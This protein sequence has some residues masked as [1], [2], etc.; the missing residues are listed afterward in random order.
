MRTKPKIINPWKVLL[1][2]SRGSISTI[3][4]LLIVIIVTVY[5]ITEENNAS[6]VKQ[7]AFSTLC[8]SERILY[9]ALQQLTSHLDLLRSLILKSKSLNFF[10]L[11]T[12]PIFT[13]SGIKLSLFLSVRYLKCCHI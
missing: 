3:Y 7:E 5:N 12:L 1:T 2:G 13:Y 8:N 9:F 6:N 4:P 10:L 11:G